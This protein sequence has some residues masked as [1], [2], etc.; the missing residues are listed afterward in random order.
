M[1]T[2]ANAAAAPLD[3][4]TP[5]RPGAPRVRREAVLALVLNLMCLAVVARHLLLPLQP[6]RLAV[7][8]FT[9]LAAGLALRLILL[10]IPLLRPATPRSLAATAAGLAGLLMIS[11]ASGVSWWFPIVPGWVIAVAPTPGRRRRARAVQQIAGPLDQ[12]AQPFE[13]PRARG[14]QRS[15]QGWP[16]A[17]RQ[18][19]DQRTQAADQSGQP[20]WQAAQQCEMSGAQ[21]GQRSGQKAA[22]IGRQSGKHRARRAGGSGVGLPVLVA[23]AVLAAT[24]PAW[25]L[26][27]G[28][29]V[30]T[31]DPLSVRAVEW[32]R[33]NGGGSEVN[34]IE[35]WWYQHH[36][37]K[38]GGAPSIPISSGAPT[39]PLNPGNPAQPAGAARA[40]SIRL[41][42]V[43]SPA[44]APLPGEGQWTVVAGT[45]ALPAIAVTRVRPDA[46]HTSLLAAIARIDPKVARL[47]LQGGTED[48]GPSWPSGG[49]VA[50]SDRPH[51]LA[52]FNSG[53]RLNEAGGGY[54]VAGR[55]ARP[56]VDGAA[57]LVFRTDGTASVDQ[58]GR[59][60][61]LG[62]EVAAV[63]Q[64][65]ALIVDQRAPVSGLDDANNIR[66]GKTLGHQVLVW[67]SGIGVT[68]DGALVWVGG[69]G[70]SIKSLGGLLVNAG[71]VR[72][73]ELDIN[74][75]WVAFFLYGAQGG[76]AGTRLL[77]DMVHAPDR[78]LRPQSRDFV[79]VL[80]R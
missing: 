60:A 76:E 21:G 13:D 57:S 73:M 9:V 54:W 67:R 25:S 18:I 43:P 71:A 26:G 2:L 50:T 69:P 45:A 14:A 32:V 16:Q 66:W 68:A 40:E 74:S 37:P 80:A 11:E 30:Q 23:V 20:R 17:A 58:W 62:P 28:L 3:P 10:R 55:S 29:T 53:F 5:S 64:N 22:R 49:Q 51:L 72:A 56:L 78:Y 52:A 7:A 12:V 59:D 4:P 70:L 24:G 36:P 77:P 63:R 65:L 15:D 79:S 41:A 39:N 8:G 35:R 1:K 31:S 33:T 6:A 61:T 75:S 44:G 38:S 42:P 27:V 34:S 47:K 48:P 19:A 46:V